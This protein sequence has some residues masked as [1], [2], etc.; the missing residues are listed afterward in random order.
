[1]DRSRRKDARPS[2][3]V[4]TL[5]AF[6]A[7]CSPPLLGTEDGGADDVISATPDVGV[8]AGMTCGPPSAPEEAGPPDA[9]PDE[10]VD[11]AAPDVAMDASAAIDASPPI[12]ADA[13]LDAIAPADSS[14]EDAEAG[15]VSDDCVAVSD[16]GDASVA[17][18]A[19]FTVIGPAPCDAPLPTTT[20]TIQNPTSTPASWTA[21]PTN[22]VLG[23]TAGTLAPGQCVTVSVSIP[24]GSPGIG[25]FHASVSVEAGGTSTVLKYLEDVYGV[26]ASVVSPTPLDFGSLPLPPDSQLFPLADG[27][28]VPVGTPNSVTKSVEVTGLVAP[29]ATCEPAVP[30]PV[31]SVPGGQF[32]FNACGFPAN[33]S[34]PMVVPGGFG[35]FSG[36]PPESGDGITCPAT[37]TFAPFSTPPA[38]F[39]ANVPLVVAGGLPFCPPV[40][41]P[42]TGQVV[43]PLDSGP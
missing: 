11:D 14:A 2:W 43:A 6:A 15:A 25:L 1:M 36:G 28:L 24:V 31:C 9:A 40:S 17:V 30:D 32:V 34:V 39:S 20:F 21:T 8:D 27:G 37:I 42:V 18:Y 29:M 19:L 35:V 26:S 41:V 3:F 5:G 4:V 38:T 7:A 23:Q 12:D 16:A 13:T 33:L 22:A 10:A